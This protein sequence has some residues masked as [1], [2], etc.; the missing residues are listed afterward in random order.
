M[1]APAIS[2]SD[3]YINDYIP[4]PCSL[5]SYRG[6][7][8]T[9]RAYSIGQVVRYQFEY[10]KVVKTITSASTRYPTDE[11]YFEKIPGWT[12]NPV[13]ANKDYPF[14]FVAIRKKQADGLWGQ[15]VPSVWSKWAADGHSPYI[16]ETTNTWWTWDEELGVYTDTGYSPVGSDGAI[17]YPAGYYDNTKWYR[18]EAGYAPYVQYGGTL[19]LLIK[20]TPNAGIPTTNTEYWKAFNNWQAVFVDSLVAAFAKIGGAVFTGNTDPSSPIKG[21]MIS[22]AGVDGT[23]N[24]SSYTGDDGTWQPKLMLDFLNGRARFEDAEVKGKITATSGELGTLTMQSGGYINL[25][26]SF[27]NRKGRLDN[28]GLSLIYDGANSQKIEWYSGL[29]TFAGQIT[30]N[31]Q[32]RLRLSSSFGIE[33]SVDFLDYSPISI[34][35]SGL[36]HSVNF[37]TAEVS[38]I[39]KLSSIGQLNMAYTTLAIPADTWYHISTDTTLIIITSAGSGSTGI[40]RITGP[41]NSSPSNGDIKIITNAT[42]NKTVYLKS[43]KPS[44]ATYNSN[45]KVPNYDGNDFHIH[46]NSSVT[47]VYYGGYWRVQTDKGQ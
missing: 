37:G 6:D 39:R 32:G 15:F 3:A 13:G 28:D 17:P 43:T 45:I 30:C 33:L 25:P 14:E 16:D 7:F 47:L 42:D 29:G 44:G 40:Y 21:R 20:D 19:Y 1:T 2:D 34:T 5:S 8:T 23:S 9:N 26:P 12:D 46:E 11:E 27:T 10:Y 36:Y 18:R 35:G 4:L 24:F 31:S 22:E 41:D 38:N